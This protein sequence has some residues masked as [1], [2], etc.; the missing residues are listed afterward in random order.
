MRQDVFSGIFPGDILQELQEMLKGDG[1]FY[2]TLGGIPRRV[3]EGCDVYI[4]M[5]NSIYAKCKAGAIMGGSQK[6]FQRDN[7]EYAVFDPNAWLV[8]SGPLII[9]KE[10][11]YYKSFRG[12][13]YT[14]SLF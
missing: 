8:L 13:R 6:S 5:E 7:G 10:I 9:A 1:M 2:F 3:T 12:I 11:I 4:C 14:E